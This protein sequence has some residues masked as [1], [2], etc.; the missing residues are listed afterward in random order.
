MARPASRAAGSRPPLRPRRCRLHCSRTPFSPLSHPTMPQRSLQ[1]S[2]MAIVVIALLVSGI[3]PTERLTWLMEVA[4]VLIALPVLIATRKNF[5]LTDLLAVLI[6]LH[7]LVLILGGA[8]T[9]AHV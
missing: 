3:A 5:P 4:P 7:A 2:L 9:Y 1:A 8:Y 6:A